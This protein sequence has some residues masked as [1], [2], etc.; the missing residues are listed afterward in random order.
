M[1]EKTQLLSTFTTTTLLDSTITAI[2]Y[3]YKLTFGKLYVL[4]NVD[5]PTQL[6]ITYNIV[7]NQAPL[8][9]LDSTVSVH[10]KKLTN[11]IYTINAINRLIEEKN[12]GILDTKYRI[13]WNEFEN[14]V[15]VTAQTKLKIIPTRLVK[16]VTV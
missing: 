14:T 12:N 13:N 1:D 7:K 15:L 9:P 8:I 5:D 3:T 6:I 16:I 2:Q 11:S 4:E 10:R